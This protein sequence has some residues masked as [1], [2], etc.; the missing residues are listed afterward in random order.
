MQ[1]TPILE[2]RSYAR[3]AD[4]CLTVAPLYALPKR[5]RKFFC[6]EDTYKTSKYDGCDKSRFYK[7]RTN[8]MTNYQINSS[9]N[10]Y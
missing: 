2:A 8:N 9:E 6:Y 10:S 1:S 3:I 5:S 7:W 4:A